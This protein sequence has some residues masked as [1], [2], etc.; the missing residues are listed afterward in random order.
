MK[1]KIDSKYIYIAI[2]LIGIVAIILLIVN[3]KKIKQSAKGMITN[4]YFSIEELC[5]SET[6]DKYNIDNTPSA[7]VEANLQALIDKVLNPVREAYGSYILVNSGYR[8]AA[9]NSKVGGVSGSQHTTGEAADI[10]GG[11][12]EKNR[13][14]FEAIVKLGVYDQLIWENGGK[15]VHVSYKAGSNRLAIL[16]YTNGIYQNISTTWQSAILA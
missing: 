11:S 10:T 7:A 15:W 16:N 3:M 9:L 4:N 12:V 8:C 2:S 5:A 1:V 13:K 14:I 6:A